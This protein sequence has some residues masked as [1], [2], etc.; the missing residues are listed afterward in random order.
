MAGSEDCLFCR[1]V[2]G[3]LPAKVVYQSQDILA[4]HDIAPAAPVHV[5]VI[6]T[7][8]VGSLTESSNAD[9]AAKL[10]MATAQVADR[11]GLENG[12]RVVINTGPDA[13]QSVGHLHAHVLGGRSLGW[14]PG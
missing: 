9:L 6:P 5:L 12:F 7:E 2:R 8:H 4:F 11:L 10:F 1:V 14:P 13:G 3:D